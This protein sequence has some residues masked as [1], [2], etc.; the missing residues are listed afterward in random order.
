LTG[1]PVRIATATAVVMTTAL[2]I[3]TQEMSRVL[4]EQHAL[5][6]RFIA[7]RL[8][9]HTRVESDLVVRPR[10]PPLRRANHPSLTPLASVPQPRPGPQQS[11]L[12]PARP[13]LPSLVAFP[14][15]AHG[16]PT[17]VF[18]HGT[19]WSGSR[20]KCVKEIDLL[21]ALRLAALAQDIALRLAALAQDIRLG[22]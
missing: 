15:I 14:R 20:A 22:P 19:V 13:T 7:H 12:A 11:K 10:R 9:R 8:S 2:V 18:A 4:H 1:R 17:A 3:E 21:A 5:S 6:D 16:C